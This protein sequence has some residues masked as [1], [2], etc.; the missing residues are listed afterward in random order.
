MAWPLAKEIARSILFGFDRH[1]S[2]FRQITAGARRRFEA[3]Q[4]SAVQASSRERIYYYDRRVN[5]T[6]EHLRGRYRIVELDEML[7]KRV[8][9]EYVRL[10]HQH[11]QPELA[12]TFYNSV[13]C[14]LFDRRYYHNH[15]IFVRPAVATDHIETDLPAYRCH[16]PARDGFPRVIA[17]IL[18]GFGFSLPFADTAQEVAGVLAQIRERK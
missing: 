14:R 11:R 17:D 5:E 16:Y 18:T 12:E 15:N 8:K 1:Y 4:W 7:W 3:A 9:V 2:L 10:L 13:F 6:V